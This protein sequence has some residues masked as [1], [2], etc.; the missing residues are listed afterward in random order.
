MDIRLERFR[1][2]CCAAAV[3]ALA[4]C[5]GGGGGSSTPTTTSVSTTVIDGPLKNVTVCLDKN[6]NGKCDADEVQ[7]KTDASGNVTLAVPNA[8]VG[9]YPILAVVGTDAIDADTGPVATAYTLTA[10]AD[11]AGVVSPLTTLV[12]QTIATTGSSTSEA[13]K[14]E[15]D[16]TG[17]T[18]SPFQDYTKTAAPTNGS[19]SAA[20]LAR[21]LVGAT[22]Q[23]TGAVA[24]AVGTRAI[25][26]ST[27]TQADLDK[28]IQKK[29]LELLPDLV[30]ALSSPSVLA[31]TTPA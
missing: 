2:A 30:T 20:T 1:L 29:L 28:A 12:Q 31:A 7:G 24:G 8:D 3:L 5:G 6:G 13:A 15:Q 14:T 11:Q 19:V 21:T 22:Q 23:Q 17:L 10:P 26:G 27:I 25:D 9:K 18:V 16:A 4:G